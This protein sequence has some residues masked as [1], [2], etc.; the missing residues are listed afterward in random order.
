ML[1]E[2]ISNISFDLQNLQI[3]IQILTR[4]SIALRKSPLSR[5]SGSYSPWEYNNAG[6]LPATTRT[7]LLSNFAWNLD[8]DKLSE[9]KKRN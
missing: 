7:L 5:S 4:S 3:E 9:V 2:L 1:I 8:V 6:K